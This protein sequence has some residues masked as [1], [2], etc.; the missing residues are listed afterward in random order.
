RRCLIKE[1]HLGHVHGTRH[2]TLD[3]AVPAVPRTFDAG[4]ETGDILEGD[5]RRRTEPDPKADN[6]WRSKK[7]HAADDI[8][9]ALNLSTQHEPLSTNA[10]RTTRLDSAALTLMEG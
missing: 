9:P 4:H 2:G 7:P 6:E 5:R 3:I 1:M 8:P 10:T